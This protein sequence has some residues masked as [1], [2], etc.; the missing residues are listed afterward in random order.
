MIACQFT[1]LRFRLSPHLNLNGIQMAK[2]RKEVGGNIEIIY[3]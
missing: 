2:E 3:L 1:Q